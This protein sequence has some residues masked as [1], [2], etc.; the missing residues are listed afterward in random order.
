MAD[1]GGGGAPGGVGYEWDFF[2]SYT[3]SDRGWAE[4]IAWE[5]ES[6]GH[7]VLVQAWHMV[8]GMSWS[9]RMAAGM[10]RSA[11][12]VAVLSPDYV[13]SDACGAEWQAAWRSDL[14]GRGR[15][16]LPVRVVEFSPPPPFDG[17]VWTDLVGVD[18]PE[19]VGRLG[20][21]VEAA[22]TGENRPSGRP[23]FP[24]AGQAGDGP[25]FPVGQAAVW[26]LP[27]ERNRHFTGREPELSE[28]RSRLVGDGVT[29]TVPRALHGLGGVGKTQLAVQYAYRHA[30]DYD[31][32]WWIPAEDPALALAALAALADRVGVAVPGQAEESAREVVD[33][34]RQ[35][36][37]F[38][39]WLLILDNAAEPADLYGLLSAAG[40]GG[41]V[42]VTTRDPAWSRL[43]GLVEVDVL[44]RDRA[45]ALLRE[46]VPRLS[47]GEA[48]R[49][50]ATVA[51][52]PLALEQAGAWLAETGTPAQEYVDLL[53]QRVS[54]VMARGVPA[55][56]AP[57][58]A[59]WTIALRT[60]DEPAVLLAR[61][62]ALF[63]PEPIPVG[64][65]RPGVAG[66][67]PE[68]LA[69]AARDPLEFRDAVGRLARTAIV[70][71]VAGDMVVMHRLVQAVLRDDTPDALRPGLREAARRLIAHGRPDD[72]AAPAGWGRYAQLYP[73]A[74]ATD[75]VDADTAEARDLT[76][77]LVSALRNQGDY[78]NSRRLAEHAHDRW[79]TELG[80]DHPDTIRVT[81][82]LAATL[83]NQ[84][85]YPAAHAMEEDLLARRRRILGDD[86]PDVLLAA[87]NLAVTLLS[88]GDYP[89]ARDL[90]EDLLARYRRVLGDNHQDTVRAMTNLAVTL[91]YQGDHQA[92]RVLRED[93][94]A[95]S[96]RILG[97][98]HPETIRAAANLAATLW[99]QGDYA[100]ARVMEEDVLARRRR[101]LGEDHPDTI[102]AVA[103]L[104]VTL[105]SQGDYAAARVMEEDVLARRR[106]ILGED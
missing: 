22:T 87:T 1:S 86:H 21:M 59:T 53:G 62:W 20:R 69:S 83:W 91:A 40:G 29:A 28:L 101:I 57:V 12:T 89:A 75:L 11:R 41:H 99:N 72:S 100:A 33:L 27:W 36:Q 54:A 6:A 15:R 94:L 48:G 45:V 24:V 32:V 76:M 50:A 102:L 14:A 49:I 95:W 44:P 92:A 96:R 43:A 67:L 9:E 37:R 26:S 63:G 84:G 85:N 81:A 30:S 55:D 79:T 80:A 7:R 66:L 10:A 8:A 64:L 93:A 56:H 46:R 34:L 47:E 42:L 23:L 73:H 19:A 60:L 35:G 2:V 68:P 88:Q 31:L 77:A 4:W 18:E 98:D 82:D 97:E 61:L 90:Q 74:L 25:R 51:D 65:I 104:A 52:L 39:H 38:P 13:E 103:N 78:P 16:L 58:A 106:R 105:R 71:L 17:I 5:L 3:Q 70:R